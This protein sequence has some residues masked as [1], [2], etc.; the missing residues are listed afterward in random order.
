M[1]QLPGSFQNLLLAV[2]ACHFWWNSLS[3]EERWSKLV[4]GAMFL[5]PNGCVSV[6]IVLVGRLPTVDCSR[7]EVICSTSSKEDTGRD[8]RARVT[9]LRISV[10]SMS[11]LAVISR[12]IC[13]HISVNSKQMQIAH[14]YDIC[15]HI[16]R[17]CLLG[18]NDL[19]DVAVLLRHLVEVAGESNGIWNDVLRVAMLDHS[20]QLCPA[21][22]SEPLAGSVL[23]H[24]VFN[25][26]CS[27]ERGKEQHDRYVQNVFIQKS[28]AVM[29][30]VGEAWVARILF[31][32]DDRC[33]QV[34]FY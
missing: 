10:L 15:Y 26:K 18:N 2:L 5:L 29:M 22:I 24:R 4:K 13:K 23:S 31:Q 11:S 12:S 30:T 34:V 20:T 8:V 14:I 33:P 25:G 27:T 17:N 16:M 21:F 1:N 7:A 3:S 6:I 32:G 9:F 19:G 28:P